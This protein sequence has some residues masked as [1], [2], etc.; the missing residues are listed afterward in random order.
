VK[1]VERFKY[2][3]LTLNK[4]G[5]KDDEIT[6]RINKRRNSG[7]LNSLLWSTNITRKTKKRLYSAIFKSNILYYT[8][9]KCGK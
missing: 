2:L 8:D 9:Q 7:A 3:G 1:G 4:Y 6:L 5:R